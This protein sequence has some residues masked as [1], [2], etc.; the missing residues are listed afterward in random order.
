MSSASILFNCIIRLYVQGHG[1]FELY[2]EFSNDII[3]S[4]YRHYEMIK[5]LFVNNNHFN[6]LLNKE[7]K[8]IKRVPDVQ[9]EMDIKIFQI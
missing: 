2:N 8:Y 9:K 6:L 4:D 5:L 1:E 7:I 3:S